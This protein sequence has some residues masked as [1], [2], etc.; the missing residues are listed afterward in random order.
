MRAV[1]IFAHTHRALHTAALPLVHGS[2]GSIYLRA[3]HL[4]DIA[5]HVLR[6]SA[7]NAAS[8]EQTRCACAQTSARCICTATYI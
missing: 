7:K 3:G 6:M 5:A 2:R 8:S 4:S 1:G